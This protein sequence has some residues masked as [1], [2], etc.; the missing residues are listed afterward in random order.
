MAVPLVVTRRTLLGAVWV[1]ASA[2]ALARA[3]VPPTPRA[4]R[5]LVMLDPGH[6]GKDPGAVGAAGTFEKHIALATAVELRRQL[7][8]G[9][10][11]RVELTR[12]GDVFVP[13]EERVRRA[14]RRGAA[15]LVSLHAD[16]LPDRG[17]RGA[18]VY[19]LSNTA[20]D[21]QTEAL[22]RRENSADRF[23]PGGRGVPPA[24]ANIL[25]S[26]VRRETR[27]GSARA[28]RELVGS[29]KGQVP[30][31]TNPARHAG[32]AVL[33]A[34]DVPSVLVEIG[35]M[36]NSLDEAAL[37]RADH[38]ARVAFAIRRALEATL[39][40]SDRGLAG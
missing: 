29:L 37:R 19:T 36:S 16:A 35:F 39:A 18:S 31:L 13:L 5:P 9:G 21:A 32:F 8:A 22:A 7:E 10:R 2:E 1:G 25:A 20:S 23:D 3:P 24:V 4:P 12:G 38:R 30:L 27:A 34:A 15:L 14:Q 26:L 28:A 11:C 17:V 33:Q 6:G 40:S